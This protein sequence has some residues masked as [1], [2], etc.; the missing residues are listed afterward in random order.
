[1]EKIRYK[2]LEE[3]KP[4]LRHGDIPLIATM[5]AHI[6]KPRTVEHQ[7]MGNRT[8]KQPVIE[9]ANKLIDSREQLFKDLI[10]K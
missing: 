8:L 9:A 7:L 2:T 6:Y 5:I 3:I 4:Q 10:S 1:M